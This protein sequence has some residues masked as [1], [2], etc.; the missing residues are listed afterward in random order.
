[1]HSGDASPCKTEI[2]GAVLAHFQNHVSRIQLLVCLQE[3]YQATGWSKHCACWREHTH[4][5]MGSG[6]D[7]SEQSCT[8]YC[9]WRTKAVA[10]PLDLSAINPNE[11]A[12][13]YAPG[14]ETGDLPKGTREAE[15]GREPR[16]CVERGLER[17]RHPGRTSH[18]QDR[19]PPLFPH[20]A[21][22][23]IRARSL[24]NLQGEAACCLARPSSRYKLFQMTPWNAL[25]VQWLRTCLAM[26]GTA[27]RSLV[28]DDPTC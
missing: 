10:F 19:A 12:L 15:Q 4:S 11:T 16:L 5:E 24:R 26:Q 17:L 22:I 25:T 28:Q 27:V 21:A 3:A 20:H 13:Q 23:P 1:M 8:T 7:K 14:M 6:C 9:R 2:Q 18:Q